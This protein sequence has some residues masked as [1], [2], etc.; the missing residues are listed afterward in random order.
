MDKHTFYVYY[1]EQGWNGD[2]KILN[3]MHWKLD[4]LILWLDYFGHVLT[5]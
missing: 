4:I 3:A 5:E 2:M 1:N